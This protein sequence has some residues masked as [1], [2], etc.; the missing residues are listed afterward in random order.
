[1][2]RGRGGGYLR[3]QQRTENDEGLFLS[4]WEIGRAFLFF[5]CILPLALFSARREGGEGGVFILFLGNEFIQY[6]YVL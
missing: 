4:D 5:V 1:M 3:V 2:F 6:A